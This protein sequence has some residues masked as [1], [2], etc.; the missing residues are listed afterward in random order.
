[1]GKP[2]ALAKT[3]LI[4]AYILHGPA[5]FEATGGHLKYYPIIYVSNSPSVI[6]LSTHFNNLY[7]MT[8]P[9]CAR[10]NN[11]LFYRHN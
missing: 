9:R 1:M 2:E 4:K 10:D 11:S 5:A 3:N 7:M 6:H 8:E